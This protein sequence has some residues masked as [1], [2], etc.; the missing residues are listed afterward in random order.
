MSARKLGKV[1][2]IQNVGDGLVE[3][4]LDLE[5]LVERAEQI[6]ED[7]NVNFQRKEATR[8]TS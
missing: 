2:V 8:G 3:G 4:E 6:V 5:A 1:R 7:P